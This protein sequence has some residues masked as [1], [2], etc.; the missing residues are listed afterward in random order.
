MVFNDAS[1]PTDIIWEN[2]HFTTADYFKRQLIAFTLVALVLAISFFTIFKIST[3]SAKVGAVF[4]PVDCEGVADMY[5]GDFLRQYA[6]D[7]YEYITAKANRQSSGTLQCFCK[8]Q[9]E[10]DP[11]NYETNTYQS[12]DNVPIC[13]EF[14]S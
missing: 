13:G 2:R 6:V 1:E 3:Y 5:E 9:S 14:N 11:D 10:K 4:P 12:A 7:D 8:L